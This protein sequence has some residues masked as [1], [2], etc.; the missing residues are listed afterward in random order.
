MIENRNRFWLDHIGGSAHVVCTLAFIFALCIVCLPPSSPGKDA[1]F[2]YAMVVVL[3]VGCFTLMSYL[4]VIAFV[5]TARLGKL[6]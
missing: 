3:L 1:I 4:C 6:W 5:L 2:P